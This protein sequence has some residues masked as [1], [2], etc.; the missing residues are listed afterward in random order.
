MSEFKGVCIGAGYFG[1]F[2]YDA[3]QRIGEVEI[4]AM[5]NR[6]L[7]RAK[8]IM[9]IFGIGNHYNDYREILEKEKPDFVDIIT[10]PPAHLEM[11]KAAADL[12]IHIICQKPLAP[13]FQEAS[14]SCGWNTHQ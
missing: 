7:G 11:C 10:T 6:N 8:T 2:Q 1:R 9:D 13:T 14:Q 4:T 12:G 3:W 5:C